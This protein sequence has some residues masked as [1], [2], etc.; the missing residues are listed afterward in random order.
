MI[1]VIDP[2]LVHLLKVVQK[3]RVKIK[4]TGRL[5]ETVKKRGN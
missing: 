5:Y 3:L 2:L 4:T 1:Q